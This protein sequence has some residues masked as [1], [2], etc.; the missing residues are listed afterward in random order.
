MT[1][2]FYT[3][4]FPASQASVRR[5]AP[6]AVWIKTPNEF[7]YP[8]ARRYYPLEVRARWNRQTLLIIEQ[9]IVITKHTVPEMEKCPEPWCVFPY[10]VGANGFLMNYGFGCTKISLEVQK[11]LSHEE[12]MSH[13]DRPCQYCGPDLNNFECADCP[14]FRHQDP[15]FRHEMM[16]RGFQPHIHEPPVRHL[17]QY[18]VEREGNVSDG[19][20][21]MFVWS[22]R[23]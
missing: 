8:T 5:H 23:Q 12:F 4:V 21:G 1:L 17:H 20:E 10:P 15:W 6:R 19:P 11:N 13:A 7:A 14:C 18:D 3:E 16:L 22:R 9:D 2:Y